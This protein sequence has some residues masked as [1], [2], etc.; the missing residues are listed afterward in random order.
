MVL[1]MGKHRNALGS[2]SHYVQAVLDYF[3]HENQKNTNLETRVPWRQI[4]QWVCAMKLLGRDDLEVVTAPL[5]SLPALSVT[6][7]VF[8]D[9]GRSPMLSVHGLHSIYLA[10]FVQAMLQLMGSYLY[11]VGSAASVKG[12]ALSIPS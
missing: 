4:D 12:A 5:I 10:F 3:C 6:L 2:G 1:E 9:A 8:V 7:Y 11:L